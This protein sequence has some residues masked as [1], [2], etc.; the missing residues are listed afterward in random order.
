MIQPLSI[1]LTYYTLFYILHHKNL[2]EN[3]YPCKKSHL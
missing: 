3:N 1:V 2:S